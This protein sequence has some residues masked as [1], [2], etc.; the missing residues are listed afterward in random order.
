MS[1]Q[2]IKNIISGEK[3][4]CI[5]GGP[6]AIS[7]P[8]ENVLVCNLSIRL[9]D[10]PLVKYFSDCNFYE[11]YKDEIDACEAQYNITSCLNFIDNDYWIF[12]QKYGYELYKD[13][14]IGNNSGLHILHIALTMG[15]DPV[16][17]SGYDLTEREHFHKDYLMGNHC[18]IK[19][20]KEFEIMQGQNVF[21]T[22]KNSALTKYFPYKN[23]KEFF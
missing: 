2:S 1:L 7:I 3:A 20:I 9:H 22:N 5:A 14:L 8:H 16:I 11:K 6:T 4:F 10:S 13:K 21:V 19:F 15:A 17:L 23:I 18:I 12:I